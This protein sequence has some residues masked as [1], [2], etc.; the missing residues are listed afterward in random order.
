[1]EKLIFYK[2][3]FI[4]FYLYKLKFIDLKKKKK[5][6][7]TIM[8]ECFTKILIIL[9]TINTKELKETDLLFQSLFGN[10]H[11]ISININNYINM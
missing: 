4:Y 9:L 7:F 1:M 5:N 10:I 2:K 3:K 11:E 8:S 6:W